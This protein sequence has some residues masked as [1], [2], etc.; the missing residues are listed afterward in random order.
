MVGVHL[1]HDY[2]TVRLHLACNDTSSQLGGN[3]IW[4]GL[5]AQACSSPSPAPQPTQRKTKDESAT[6]NAR[7][8]SCSV[9][10]DDNFVELWMVG[11]RRA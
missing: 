3:P 6:S 9:P 5:H 2:F 4:N 10:F 7:G 8:S 11:A 1:A